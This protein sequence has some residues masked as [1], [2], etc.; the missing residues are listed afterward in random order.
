MTCRRSR[1]RSSS[2]ASGPGLGREVPLAGVLF[3]VGALLLAAAAPLTLYFGKSMLERAASDAGYGWLVPV[4]ILSSALTAGAVLRVTGRVFLGWGPREG[5]GSQPVARRAGARRRNPRLPRS[6]PRGDAGGSG[7]AA[8]RRRRGGP[9]ARSDSGRRARRG[10]LHRP[11]RLPGLGD[12][13]RPRPLARG[14][15]VAH[16]GHRCRLCRHQRGRCARVGGARLFG[17]P[18]WEGLPTGLRQPARSGMRTLRH[19]HSGEIG[20]YI[21]WWTAGRRC[22]EGSVCWHCAE[23]ARWTF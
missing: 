18:L 16:R 14:G 9:R 5:P 22:W 23:R 6:H 17:R 10:P 7:R 20:D 13:R 11:R 12:R 2:R 3:A 21:A 19:L 4:F 15:V 1:P 8:P